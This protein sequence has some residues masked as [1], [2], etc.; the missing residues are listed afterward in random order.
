MFTSTTTFAP[1]IKIYHNALPKE[2]NLVNRY[3]NALTGETSEYL[4]WQGAKVGY[5]ESNS[6]HRNCQDFKYK[7]HEIIETSEDANELKTMHALVMRS[8]RE[9]LD[10]YTSEYGIDI[11]YIEALNV[12]KYGPGEYF[13]VHSDDGEP[14]R[15]TVSA[16]GYVNDD[17]EGGELFY[18]YFNSTYT[19]VAGDFVLFPSSYVYAHASLPVKSGIKY[20]LVIMTDRNEFAHVKD[21]PIYHK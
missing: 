2:W 1:G 20:S 21:S 6:S 9:C 13:K 14:Y 17:Y 5:H 19:P 12:V 4:K 3:E 8:L 7:S 15:C 18:Q 16:V 11:Q 10:D